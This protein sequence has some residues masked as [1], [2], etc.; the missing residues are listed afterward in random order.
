MA[1]R[2]EIKPLLIPDP[3]VAQR[4]AV[5]TRTLARWDTDEALGFPPPIYIRERR[6]RDLALLEAWDRANSKKAASKPMRNRDLSKA[7]GKR[8]PRRSG[9]QR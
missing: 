3:D 8:C 6:Y 2:P 7:R 1:K 5:C 9:K 4:Y